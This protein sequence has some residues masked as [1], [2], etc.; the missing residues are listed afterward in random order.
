MVSGLNTSQNC[1]LGMKHSDPSGHQRQGLLSAPRDRT[2]QGKAAFRVY[3]PSLW[4]K[5]KQQPPPFS[6]MQASKLTETAT[7]TS[8][9]TYV[10]CKQQCHDVSL[11]TIQRKV[12]LIFDESAFTCPR[13]VMLQVVSSP[14]LTCS[15]SKLD[16]GTSSYTPY[17]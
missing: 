14:L 3:A 10:P 6:Y 7:I 5:L 11:R 16:K 1:S 9:C 8:A 12:Q 13:L 2:K 4:N 15:H 17:D